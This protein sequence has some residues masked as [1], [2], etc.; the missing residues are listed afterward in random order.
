MLAY[1]LL[2]VVTRI[3]GSKR[4]HATDE[5]DAVFYVSNAAGFYLAF[6]EQFR[7]GLYTDGAP[8]RGT[9]AI[10]ERLYK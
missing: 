2:K 10:G 9:H 7:A 5:T 8:G 4:R 3:Y 1:K 6:I